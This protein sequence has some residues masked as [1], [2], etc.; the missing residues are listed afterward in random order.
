MS[1]FGPL[2]LLEPMPWLMLAAALRFLSTSAVQPVG[3]L[4]HIGAHVALFLALLI[5][6]RRMLEWSASGGGGLGAQGFR[7][8]LQLS[9][10]VLLRMLALMALAL[11]VAFP[12]APTAYAVQALAGFDGI[13]FDQWTLPG[14]LWSSLLAALIFCMLLDADAGRP[15]TFAN[16]ARQFWRHAAELSLAIL[17]IATLQTGVSFLQE[18]GRDLVR[19]IFRLA[20][21]TPLK[22][23]TYLIFVVGF[24]AIRLWVTIAVLAFATGS[25]SA[26]GG[27]ATATGRSAPPQDSQRKGLT[28]K[29]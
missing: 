19:F 15:V 10:V 9:K 16:A 27:D 6:A 5:A 14:R 20:L 24:A 7:E 12:F 26:E 22:N 28:A 25:R 1:T 17:I 18:F 23:L 2:R 13:A 3:L 21:P 11:A 8:Q 4:A 29:R